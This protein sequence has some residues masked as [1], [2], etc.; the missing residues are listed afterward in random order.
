MVQ[1]QRVGIRELKQ[2]PSEIIAKAA[3]GVRFEVLSNGKPVGVIIQRDVAIRSR[4]VNTEALAALSAATGSGLGGSDTTGWA[5]ELRADR[6]RETEQHI[7][8]IA[9]PWDP[10]SRGPS[11]DRATP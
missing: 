3:S 6:E 4:W 9:D 10:G 7:D 11:T 2:N 5:L 8:Q 1:P